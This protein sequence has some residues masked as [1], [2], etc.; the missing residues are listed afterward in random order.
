MTNRRR[1]RR[2]QRLYVV[3]EKRKYWEIERG[4][5]RAHFVENS[6]CTKLWICHS[7]RRTRTVFKDKVLRKL[8]V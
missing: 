3:K 5:T 7:D 8:S 6:L 1:R 2:K 4:S